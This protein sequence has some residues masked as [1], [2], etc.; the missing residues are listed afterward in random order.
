MTSAA[1]EPGTPAV[2]AR[3]L[4]KSFGGRTALDGLSFQIKKGCTYGIIGPNGAGKT[5][6]IRIAVGLSRPD[7]GEIV[8]LGRKMPDRSAAGLI[9]YMTQKSALYNDLTIRENLAFFAALYGLWGAS[10]KKRIEE[11]LELVD[12]SARRN[13]LVGNLSGGMV[14]RASLAAALLHKPELI[15][16]D[17]PTAGVDPEL[18][19][20]FWEHFERLNREGAT[21]MVSTHHL[22]E[23]SRCHKLG[24][25]RDGRLIAEGSP[26]ELLQRTGADSL[27]RAF[28]VIAGRGEKK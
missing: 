23:A 27:E 7:G 12:L 2:E 10:G 6:F 25:L 11:V 14:Q 13:D 17:E 9:G 28:L 21:L 4:Y 22:D 3:G 26:E 16:L 8:V 20:S 15:F 1:G 5:T 19:L 24:M 18:R